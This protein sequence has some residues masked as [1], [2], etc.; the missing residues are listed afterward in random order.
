MFFCPFF[1]KYALPGVV[2]IELCTGNLLC[3]FLCYPPFGQISEWNK[4]S[5]IRAQSV[6]G[7]SSK[8]GA[9]L[10]VSSSRS[11]SSTTHTRSSH[12]TSDA[13][14]L[15]IEFKN[16]LNSR[17]CVS[18]V[19]QKVYYNWCCNIVEIW[20]L[21]CSTISSQQ[22]IK[23]FAPRRREKSLSML[24]CFDQ[25]QSYW[26]CNNQFAFHQLLLQ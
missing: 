17:Q 21:L 7:I 18:C 5:T 10:C 20:T 23:T 13:A 8:R 1:P 9:K 16:A 12:Q 11:S 19:Q 15:F 6:G 26:P 24:R 14:D 22:E 2:N 4:I 3:G 25:L